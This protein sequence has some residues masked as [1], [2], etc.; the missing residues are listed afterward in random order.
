MSFI[1]FG[2][3]KNA[4]RDWTEEL[5]E[6]KARL[7]SQRCDV[8]LKLAK[9]TMSKHQL[10]FMLWRDWV[11]REAYSDTLLKKMMDKMLRSAGLMVYN[12][13]TR[14]K[15]DTFNDIERRRMLTRNRKLNGMM[16]VL[17]HK[18]RNHLKSGF[19]SI[20]GDSLNTA[21]KQRIINK[22]GNAC[23][24]RM[25]AAWDSWKYDTFAKLK[26]EMERKKAMVCDT[27]VR[28]NM[29]PF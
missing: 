23:F 29:S 15:L 6:Y 28:N 11:K 20:A 1:A 14:W 27:L 7:D 4:F 19:N 2:R 16:E 3:L 10:A 25:K 9:A 22:L 24:G 26:S 17:D 18:H 12:L 8:I 5:S 21:S 13:F